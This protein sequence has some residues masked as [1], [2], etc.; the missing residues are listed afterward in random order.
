LRVLDAAAPDRLRELSTLDLLNDQQSEFGRLMPSA[1]PMDLAVQ[2]GWAYGATTQLVVVDVREPREPRQVAALGLPSQPMP[3]VI[4]NAPIAAPNFAARVVAAGDRLYLHDGGA[5]IGVVNVVDIHDPRHPTLLAV[6]QP[7][8]SDFAAGDYSAYLQRQEFVGVA[9]RGTI[10][11]LTAAS[12]S[13]IMTGRATDP[14]PGLHIVNLSD[15]ARIVEL[16]FLAI[17]GEWAFAIAVADDHAYLVTMVEDGASR[18]RDY[19]LHVVDVANSRTPVALARH[20]LASSFF[21]QLRVVDSIVYIA[22]GDAVQAVDVR[23][24]ARPVDLA[25]QRVAGGVSGLAVDGRTVYVAAGNGGLALLRL[26]GANAPPAAP[27]QRAS[28]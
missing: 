3:S 8:G 27:R 14:P 17:P 28:N 25:T 18:R 13:A 24:P 21:A 9:V 4:G 5:G 16:G 2:G 23:D 26:T 11:Y 22:A 20:P 19:Y 1:T 12:T 10:G 6:Y 7:P 15:P